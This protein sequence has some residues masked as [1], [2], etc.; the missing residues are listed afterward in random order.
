M[1]NNPIKYFICYRSSWTVFGFVSLVYDR[2]GI[3]STTKENV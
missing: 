3:S 2:N 1:V